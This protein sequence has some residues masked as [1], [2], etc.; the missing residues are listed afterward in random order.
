MIMVNAPILDK[1]LNHFSLSFT[2]TLFL[3]MCEMNKR[4]GYYGTKGVVDR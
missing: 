4:L 3:N 1:T 2:Y